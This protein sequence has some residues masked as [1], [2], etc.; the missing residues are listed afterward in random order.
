MRLVPLFFALAA[1]TG[2][3]P[4]PKLEPTTPASAAPPSPAAAVFS[5]GRA[6][7]ARGLFAQAEHAYLYALEQTPDNPQ[8]HYY[9]GVVL[10][11]QSRFAEAQ[12]QF[13]KSLALKPDYA[14]PRIAMGKMLYDVHGR[15]QEARKLLTEALALAPDAVE[16]HYTLGVINQREGELGAAREIFAAIAAADSN[17]LQARTQLGLIYLQEGDYQQAQDQL[18]RVAHRNPHDP[19]VFHGLGQ[20]ALRAGKG[21]EGQRYLERARLL[22]EQNAQLGPHQDAVRQHPEAPQ[23]HSNLASFYNRFG[24]LKLAVEHYRESIVLDSTYG[25]GYQGLGNLYQ[26]RGDDARAARY[27]LEALRW[28]STLAESHNNLGLLFHKKRELAKAAQQYRRAVRLAPDIAHYHSNLGNIYLEMERLT[29]AEAAAG[30]AIRLDSTFYSAQI[31]L[32]DIHARQGSYSAAIARWRAVP[33]KGAV[34]QQLD[35]KIAAAQKRLSAP[36]R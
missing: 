8:Y 5:S 13:E 2:E 28:D 23:A 9:L 12:T 33:A 14:G 27:Y 34:K 30:R 26:R 18:R 36:H 31:L 24:R 20:A 17:H 10:H 16:A 1:C 35:E 7:Q 29:E 25:P 22:G 19:A 21:E 6:L 15:A 32:G 4:E 11:A 3:P